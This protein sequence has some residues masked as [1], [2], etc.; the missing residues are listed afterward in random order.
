MSEAVGE[1]PKAGRYARLA[2][3]AL[4]E[5]VDRENA[6]VWAEVEAK[7]A[8]AVWNGFP[9]RIDPH[10]LTNARH[11][12]TD[13]GV[14]DHE[15]SA[16]RGGRQVEILVSTSAPKRAVQAAAAR[17]RLLHARYLGWA[18]G[19]KR[20]GE[21]I[22]GPGAEKVVHESLMAAAPSGYRVLEPQRGEVRQMFGLPVPGGP[23]DNGA[24][25][26]LVDEKGFPAGTVV[27]PIEVKN[28]RDWVYPEAPELHQLLSKAAALQRAQP[29]LRF[30]PVL[31][32]RRAQYTTFRM[33]RALGFY[34]VALR[35]QFLL[36][37]PDV[38]PDKVDEVCRELGY[39]LEV[40]DEAFPYLVRQFTDTFPGVA[41]RTAER[42]A[43][44]G[45]ALEEL[46]SEIRRED[47][48]RRRSDL[49][50]LLRSEA[51]ELA[52]EGDDQGG[53]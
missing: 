23:L 27:V 1:G 18:M 35:R 31:V 48:Q 5:M 37:R 53:W 22:V 28:R 47:R 15:V 9:T 38:D 51:E 40:R 20:Y 33:A 52:D 3:Q 43:R 2:V 4:T 8:D 44:N 29:N 13:Q 6:V 50:D 49:M 41:A 7:A 11:Q 16:T 45:P 21:G 24:T 14:V 12:L 42:W 32:C 10:H 19:T 25:L 26:Q 36:P 46:F 17:K 34:V 30:A 39:D